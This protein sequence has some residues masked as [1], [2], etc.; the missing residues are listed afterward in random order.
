MKLFRK[1]TLGLAFVTAILS[2][3]LA[4]S[5]Q[6]HHSPFSGSKIEYMGTK[7]TGKSQK[8]ESEFQ[9]IYKVDAQRISARLN[10]YQFHV[11]YTSDDESVVNTAPIAVQERL[12]NK[13]RWL[14]VGYH[15]KANTYFSYGRDLNSK[16]WRITAETNTEI[17]PRIN[18]VGKVG[19]SDKLK[20][21][22]KSKTW[23]SVG[24]DYMLTKNVSLKGAYEVGNDG[25]RNVSDR[26]LLGLSFSLN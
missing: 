19:H 16:I 15:T 1:S 26:Y 4:S 13:R 14:D 2:T 11:G 18:F 20:D 6:A 17:R 12:D 8:W 10:Y 3:A 21:G 22:K 23:A 25:Q 9:N 5:A 7:I 24:L